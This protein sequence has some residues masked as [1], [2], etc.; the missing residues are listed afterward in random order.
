M[1]SAAAHRPPKG[2]PHVFTQ[3]LQ[4]SFDG[5]PS[6]FAPQYVSLISFLLLC[7]VLSIPLFHGAVHRG[8]SFSL[9][10]INL[11]MLR[12]PISFKCMLSGWYCLFL[13][14]A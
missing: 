1:Y 10:Q 4:F 14:L 6:H 13:T 12:P 3:P 8:I 2:E 7:Y 9:L 5:H 11:P